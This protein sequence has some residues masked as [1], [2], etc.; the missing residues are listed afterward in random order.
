M[1][2]ITRTIRS[3]MKERKWYK[4]IKKRKRRSDWKKEVN[5]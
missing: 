2:K 3:S 1:K 5:K 4:V